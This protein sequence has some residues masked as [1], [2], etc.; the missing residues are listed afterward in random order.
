M[1]LDSCHCLNVTV[2][3]KMPHEP[4][5]TEPYVRW[6]ERTGEA[7]PP[8]TRL[9]ARQ[10][11]LTWRCKSFTRPAEGSVSRTARAFIVRWCLKEADGKARL[12]RTGI[13]YEAY[14]SDEKANIFKVRNLLK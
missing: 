3:F 8:P 13:A 7:T 1:H 2:V 9:C 5:Y 14:E 10:G 4:P 6:C 12:R 11:A